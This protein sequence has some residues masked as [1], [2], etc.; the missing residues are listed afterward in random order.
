MNT[1]SDLSDY[2]VI[3]QDLPTSPFDETPIIPTLVV[4][5]S[6]IVGIIYVHLRHLSSSHHFMGMLFNK[7]LQAGISPSN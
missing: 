5:L 6:V 7:L 2:Q 1:Y 3:Q 4:E